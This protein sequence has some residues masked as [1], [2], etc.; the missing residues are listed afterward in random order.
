MAVEPR[1][2]N[3]REAERTEERLKVARSA[4]VP[5]VVEE[6]D[7]RESSSGTKHPQS[8]LDQVSFVQLGLDLVK[9]EIARHDSKLVL[10]KG[11]ARC[12]SAYE[13]DPIIHMCQVRVVLAHGLRVL[14][15]RPQ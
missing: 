12:R 10:A 4:V 14:P 11:Q 9:R 2:I 1:Q 6:V 8:L 5:V 3:P 7:E 15:A 13:C